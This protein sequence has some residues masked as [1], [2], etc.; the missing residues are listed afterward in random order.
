LDRK[1]Y[2]LLQYF[3]PFGVK[4]PAP[5]FVARGVQVA[6]APRVVGDGHL[7]LELR[8]G[9]AQLGAIGFRMADRLAELEASRKPLDVAFQLQEN[10]W[11]GRSELQARLVDLRPAEG[12]PV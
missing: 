1:F 6:G 5:V 2:D 3:G 12:E 9:T 4:N 10:T 8:Q 11:N 7:K